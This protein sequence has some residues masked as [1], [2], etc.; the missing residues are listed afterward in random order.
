MSGRRLR[1]G[2]RHATRRGHA[3]AWS[4]AGAFL[5]VAGLVAVIALLG[6]GLLRGALDDEARPGGPPPSVVPEV[7]QT[8]APAPSTTP[9][10]SLNR[11]ANPGFSR[12]LNGWVPTRSTFAGWT[13][14]GHGDEGA[15]ALRVNPRTGPVPESTSEPG[16]IGITAPA[17]S[18]TGAGQKVSASIWLRPSAPGATAVLR[19]VERGDGRVVGSAAATAALG[20][21]GWRQVQVAYTTRSPAAR[22]DLELRVSGL[23]DVAIL[24]ADDAEVAID[25]T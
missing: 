5:A 12:D 10:G 15:V 25:Q 11:L 21:T 19:L 7:P 16:S 17:L 3:A 2:P 22:I 4:R 8:S 1:S 20:G 18:T 9:T 6:N 13:A 23:G 14:K 24:V